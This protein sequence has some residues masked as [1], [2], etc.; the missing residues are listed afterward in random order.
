MIHFF[1]L[2]AQTF[3]VEKLY[4][5]ILTTLPQMQNGDELIVSLGNKDYPSFW[6][7]TSGLMRSAEKQGLLDRFA[8]RPLVLQAPTIALQF[9]LLLDGHTQTLAAWLENYK[10]APPK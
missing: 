4:H 5:T 8:G 1:D 2:T 10:P 3:A 6:Q 9:R 7:Q